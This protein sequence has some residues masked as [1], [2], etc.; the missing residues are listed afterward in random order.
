MSWRC[1]IL[2]PTLQR[3]AVLPLHDNLTLHIH[4]VASQAYGFIAETILCTRFFMSPFI[5]R[6]AFDLRP[7]PRCLNSLDRT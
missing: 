4:P 7:P 6:H 1:E 3:L 5:V 2:G